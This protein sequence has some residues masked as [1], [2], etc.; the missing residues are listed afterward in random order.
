MYECPNCAANLKYDIRRQQLFCE[1]CET[2][3]DPYA[4]QKNQDAEENDFYEVTVF[5]CPQCGGELLTEDTTISTFCSYCGGATILD[6]RISKE[7]RPAYIIPFSQTKEHCKTAYAKFV[8]KAF[9]APKELKDP[10]YIERFRGIYMPYWVYS[11][12]KNGEAT[13]H[14]KGE[15]SKNWQVTN[16]YDV[17]CPV[18]ADY[19]DIAFD[20]SSTFYDNLSH[21]IAPFNMHYKKPFTPSF[22]SGFYADSNDVDSSVYQKEAEELVL[23]DIADHLNKNDGLSKYKVGD[24][25]KESSMTDTLKPEIAKAELSLL[26]VWFLSY[27]NKDRVAYAVVNGQTGEVAADLPIEVRKLF[28]SSLLLTLPI[29]LL[30]NLLFTFT[31]PVFLG[32]CSVIASIFAILAN[33]MTTDILLKESVDDWRL[34]KMQVLE[35]KRQKKKMRDFLFC[36]LLVFLEL[37][38]LIGALFAL[39]TSGLSIV[40]LIVAVIVFLGYLLSD[41]KALRKPADIYFVNLDL[42]EHYWRKKLFV[43]LT[44]VP[45]IVISLITIL[46]NPVSDLWY[47][48][49]GLLCIGILIACICNIINCHNILTTRKMPQLGKRGGD[50]YA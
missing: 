18:H 38:F 43:V 2:S 10:K 28:L 8:R 16:H 29:F 46:V 49:Y 35:Q 17:K 4:F 19:D 39:I 34:L 14:G 42:Y 6:S 45:A 27:R 44:P 20:A 5:T 50:E 23:H 41:L 1:Y 11:F 30:F 3:M 25:L 40:L 48:G 7:K 12:R 37:P 31:P 21:T 13:F 26:P 47:Y 24:L 32:I 15:D 33:N 9:L 36:T 22:L